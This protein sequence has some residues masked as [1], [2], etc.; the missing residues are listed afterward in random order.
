MKI[1]KYFTRKEVACRC[2]CGLDTMDGE[3]LKI[4]DL[5]RS[6]VEKPVIVNSGARCLEYNRKI[7][8]KDTSQH[9]KCRAMDLSWDGI[10]KNEVR[11]VYE[12]LN[13]EYPNSLGI[14]RY[15]NFIHIDTRSGKF[16]R[17]EGK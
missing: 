3:T 8:S 6:F 2:G 13:R 11:L 15:S 12:Y 17:W 10:T 16:A 14:G 1:S 7:G 4:A 5:V 9:V